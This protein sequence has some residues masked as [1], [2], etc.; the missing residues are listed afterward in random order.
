MVAPIRQIVTVGDDGLIEI[1]AA[2]LPPGSK[3]GVTVMPVEP[4]QQTAHQTIEALNAL[5]K[6]LNLDEKTANEWIESVREARGSFP[7]DK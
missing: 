7:R 1:R 3:A 4:P 5:Q 6:S 2:H